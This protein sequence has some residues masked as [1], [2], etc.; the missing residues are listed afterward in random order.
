MNA[1]SSAVRTGLAFGAAEAV[2]LLKYLLMPLLSFSCRSAS[3]SRFRFAERRCQYD[4]TLEGPKRKPDTTHLLCRALEDLHHYRYRHMP[5]LHFANPRDH[6]LRIPRRCRRLRSRPGLIFFLRP[7]CTLPRR[8]LRKHPLL[9][10]LGRSRNQSCQTHVQRGVSPELMPVQLGVRKP[11]CCGFQEDDAIMRSSPVKSILWVCVKYVV[12]IGIVCLDRGETRRNAKLKVP[13]DA[14]GYADISDRL[15]LRRDQIFD[16]Q[17]SPSGIAGSQ[18][19]RFFGPH[20]INR[21]VFRSFTPD[22]TSDSPT[23]LET[24]D[25]TKIPA[26][27]QSRATTPS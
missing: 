20:L 27:W 25:T 8:R 7:S 1:S 24:D 3:S 10:R 18:V 19:P 26:Q 15:W 5:A 6:R 12:M 9:P 14:T 4:A 17:F 13:I 23:T 11:L 22:L 16:F 2:F 21:A